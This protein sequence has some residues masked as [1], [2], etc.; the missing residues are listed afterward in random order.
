MCSDSVGGYDCVCKSGFTGVHC[1]NGEEEMSAS[2]L[3]IQFSFGVWVLQPS[4][5]C[6]H[7]ADQT[8]CTLEKDKGCSQFCKPGYT[9]YECSCA[10]GWKLSRTDRNK[11]E[12][13]GT[14]V[15]RI[16]VQLEMLFFLHLQHEKIADKTRN[17]KGT[18]MQTWAHVLSCTLACWT[19]VAP[20]CHVMAYIWV[21]EVTIS[22]SERSLTGACLTM[23][24]KKYSV[25]WQIKKVFITF[26]KMH[27]LFTN[28]NKAPPC[29]VWCRGKVGVTFSISEDDRLGVRDK[30]WFRFR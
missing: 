10:R 11:C 24:M 12:P 23:W 16:K 26:S 21:T 4:P 25:R 6:F 28:Y 13:A 20:V 9:S 2:S 29:E 17:R 14:S 22:F 19:S 30:V 1:E 3:L 27:L 15:S 18:N 5:L 7:H 8:L